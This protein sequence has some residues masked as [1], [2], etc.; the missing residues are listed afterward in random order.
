MER[1]ALERRGWV[2]SSSRA[3]DASGFEKGRLGEVG[4]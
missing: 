2:G 1:G 4:L 3:W